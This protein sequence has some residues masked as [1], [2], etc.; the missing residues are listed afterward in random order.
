[1]LTIV[2][3]SMSEVDSSLEDVS[4][5]VDDIATAVSELRWLEDTGR[6]PRVTQF[7]ETGDT[8]Q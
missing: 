5:F 6:K 4:V 2:L 7:L 8:T 1:M 3:K